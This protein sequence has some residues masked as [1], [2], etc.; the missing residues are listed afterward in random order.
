MCG[1]PVKLHCRQ[2]HILDRCYTRSRGRHI[3]EPP[4]EIEKTISSLCIFLVLLHSS[5]C[6]ASKQDESCRIQ[7][8]GDEQYLLNLWWLKLYIALPRQPV[9]VGA[10]CHVMDVA[11]AAVWLQG[12]HCTGEA[13]EA[14]PQAMRVL[15]SAWH[16]LLSVFYL[17]FTCI[18]YKAGSFESGLLFLGDSP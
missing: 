9:K 16:A 3:L 4:I 14:A 2:I 17:R 13:M 5:L 10:N 6:V 12:C 8:A 15:L 1:V 11:P 7:G 18:L